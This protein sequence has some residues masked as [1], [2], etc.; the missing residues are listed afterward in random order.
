M[1]SGDHAHNF[2]KLNLMKEESDWY[3]NFLDN[4]VIKMLKSIL[5]P[6]FAANLESSSLSSS[7]SW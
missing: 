6:T 7:F 2:V 3:Q 5:L 1:I 4:D